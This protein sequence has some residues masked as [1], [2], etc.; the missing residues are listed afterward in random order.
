MDWLPIGLMPLQSLAKILILFGVVLVLAGG[1]LWFGARAGLG[2]LPGDISMRRGPVSVY[3]P[4][5]S[6]IVVSVVLSIVLNVL[7]RFFR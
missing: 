3:F 1:V 4:L 5:V 6:C 2:Q 7:A